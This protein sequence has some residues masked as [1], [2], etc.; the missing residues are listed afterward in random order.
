MKK[1][2]SKVVLITGSSSGIGL[3]TA[4]KF[5]ENGYIV[6]GM[7]K[8]DISNELLKSNIK[9]KHF[10]LD[11][12]IDELPDISDDINIL[13]CNH[14]ELNGIN[15]YRSNVAGYVRVVDKYAYNKNIKSVI[16]VSS[17]SALTGF[18]DPSYCLHQGARLTYMKHL[19]IDLGKLYK[20]RVNAISPGAVKTSLEPKLYENKTLMNK[21]AKQNLLNRWINPNEVADIIYFMSAIQTCITGQNIIVD[22]GETSNYNYIKSY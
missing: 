3:Q 12:G 14:G 11:L 19:A 6:Y 5:L 22:C 8:N 20:A 16:I 21:V 2:N 17:I 18:G 10:I 1:T 4:I 7:D 13:I 15:S 9:Y